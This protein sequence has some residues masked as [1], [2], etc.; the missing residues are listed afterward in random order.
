MSPPKLR[1]GLGELATARRLLGFPTV[2]RTS[3]GGTPADKLAIS[4]GSTL[5]RRGLQVAARS[6]HTGSLWGST[7]EKAAAPAVPRSIL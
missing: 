7:W 4:G 5:R 3:F 1:G 2:T 6:Q